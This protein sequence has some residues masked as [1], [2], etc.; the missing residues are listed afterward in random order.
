M[1]SMSSGHVDLLGA[2]PVFLAMTVLLVAP[3]W[4][5]AREAS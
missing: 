4:R 5:E 3:A 2:A 1:S